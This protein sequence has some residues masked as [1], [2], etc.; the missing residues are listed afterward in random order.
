MDHAHIASVA[1]PTG[2]Y[3]AAG[4]V[5]GWSSQRH[6]GIGPRG[7][8]LIHRAKTYGLELKA[9]GGRIT[10]VQRTAH[11]LMR[12]AGAEVEVAVGIDEAVHQLEQWGLLRG[13]ASLFTGRS[14]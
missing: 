5:P 11:V 9:G 8:I 4:A 7:V 14:A 13:H 3:A 6:K 2:G 10:P 1:G 12:A